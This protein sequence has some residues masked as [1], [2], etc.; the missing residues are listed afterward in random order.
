MNF[1]DAHFGEILLSLLIVFFV[2]M[3]VVFS[4][5]HMDKL[6]ETSFTIGAADLV[7]AL[8][9]KITPNGFKSISSNNSS[10]GEEK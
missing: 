6:A 7:G 5:L 9:M 10:K 2:A 8:T 1:W 4:H 3:A